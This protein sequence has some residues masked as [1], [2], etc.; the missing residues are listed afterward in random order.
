M[1]RQRMGDLLARIGR[2][3]PHDIDEILAEQRHRRQP[4]G[5]IA[6]S[7]GFCEPEHVWAAWCS[8]L[9]DRVE[10]VDLDRIGIDSQATEFLPRE[11]ALGRPALPIRIWENMLVVAVCDPTR[12]TGVAEFARRAGMEVRCVLAPANQIDRGLARYYP[13]LPAAG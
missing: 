3:T 13:P 6:I 4:F 7:L 11:L 10:A 2:L 5:Q 8:Q 9:V 1:D 12:A